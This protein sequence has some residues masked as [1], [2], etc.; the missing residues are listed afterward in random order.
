[1][2]DVIHNQLQIELMT[3]V[4]DGMKEHDWSQDEM[5]RRSGVLQPNI[6][7]LL[8][9]KRKGTLDTWNKLLRALESA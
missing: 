2:S 7:H 9:G 1:M 3:K 6:S 8:T 4:R 5:A